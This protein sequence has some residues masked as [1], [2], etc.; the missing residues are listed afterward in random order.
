MDTQTKRLKWIWAFKCPSVSYT[1]CSIN[2]N[3]NNACNIFKLFTFL[4]VLQKHCAPK[5]EV[6]GII[7]I[8]IIIIVIIITVA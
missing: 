2:C 8:I 5:V 7:I 6:G 1:G 3:K 4:K